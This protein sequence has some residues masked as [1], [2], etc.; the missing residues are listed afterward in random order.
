MKNREQGSRFFSWGE[1]PEIVFRN[2][3]SEHVS[4]CSE[5]SNWDRFSNQELFSFSY[6][7]NIKLLKNC[8]LPFIPLHVK[9]N[10]YTCR[11]I[12][13][14]LFI[15]NSMMSAWLDVHTALSLS[16]SVYEMGIF[17]FKAVWDLQSRYFQVSWDGSAFQLKLQ[18]NHVQSTFLQKKN[19]FTDTKLHRQ[20]QSF[21]IPPKYSF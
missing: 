2:I 18:K 14:Q 5:P 1:T 10:F 21:L 11:E 9:E 8:I 15:W 3:P 4:F 6:S 17:L 7:L 19:I 20:L 12:S 16:G 13:A